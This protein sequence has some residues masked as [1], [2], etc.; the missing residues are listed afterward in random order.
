MKVKFRIPTQYL[1]PWSPQH[2]IS[3]AMTAEMLS[4]SEDT[5]LRMI[6]EGEI[7]AYKLRKKRNSPWRVNYHS[8]LGYVDRM[9]DEHGLDK[10]FSL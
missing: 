7:K 2:T 10:R 5:V 4:V 3:V 8:V 1:M 6:E 9:H